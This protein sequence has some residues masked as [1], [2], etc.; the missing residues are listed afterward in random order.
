[1]KAKLTPKGLA[2]MARIEE[3][4][5][6]QFPA[7]TKDQFYDALDRATYLGDDPSRTI[8]VRGMAGLVCPVLAKSEHSG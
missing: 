5:R 6:V 7:I 1:M 8:T 3:L 2:A 4:V